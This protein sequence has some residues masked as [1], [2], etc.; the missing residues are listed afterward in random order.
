[1]FYTLQIINLIYHWQS[2]TSVYD[3]IITYYYVK[4]EYPMT[5]LINKSLIEN[6]II[7]VI[8]VRVNSMHF[9]NI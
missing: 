3:I 2:K 9:N 8:I 7:I 4:N 6:I 1:M 5:I